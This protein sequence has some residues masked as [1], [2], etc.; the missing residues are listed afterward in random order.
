M[1]LGIY[2]KVD[3]F[4]TGEIEMWKVLFHA[5]IFLSLPAGYKRTFGKAEEKI[6]EENRWEWK[7]FGKIRT[8]E[9]LEAYLSGREYSHG[10]YCHYTDIDT[11]NKILKG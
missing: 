6:M 1:E 2:K 11:V 10:D 9:D 7:D 3:L 8:C 5:P 4:V